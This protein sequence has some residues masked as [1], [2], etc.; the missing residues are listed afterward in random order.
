[1]RT[2]S[3][4]KSIIEPGRPAS[5]SYMAAQ[6]VRM[7]LLAIHRELSFVPLDAAESFLD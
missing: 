3:G 1:M 7:N 5:L 6:A 4:K 2:L